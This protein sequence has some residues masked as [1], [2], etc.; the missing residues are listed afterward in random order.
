IQTL[1]AWIDQGAPWPDGVTLASEESA[2]AENSKVKSLHAAIRDGNLPL[3]AKLL[4]ADRELANAR[5]RHGETPLMHVGVYSDAAMVKLLLDRGADVNL[6]SREG[7]T[8]L[9]RSAGDF[10]NVALLLAHGA[11]VDAKSN[12]GRT[13]L[14][15]AAAF[16]GNVKTV[17]L[18]MDRG[19]NVNDQDQY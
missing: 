9:M 12:M 5:D 8:A 7:A 16:P 14:L 15:V 13:A 4:E 1:K 2:T 18:L 10:D 19:A 17:R 11:K 3:V 6:A